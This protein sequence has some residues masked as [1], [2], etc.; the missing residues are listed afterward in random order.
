[1]DATKVKAINKWDMADASKDS[2]IEALIPHY[3]GMAE[4]YCNRAFSPPLPFKVE[5]Y[6]AK[7]IARDFTQQQGISS[8]SMGSVSYSYDGDTDEKLNAII[9][10]LRKLNWGGSH[11]HE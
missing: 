7:S 4:E 10:P 2:Q 9:K 6:I 11:V 3:Q 5:Q 8:R 1:M